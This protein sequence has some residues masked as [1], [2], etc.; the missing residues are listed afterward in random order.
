[1]ARWGDGVVSAPELG[2]AEALALCCRG[3]DAPDHAAFRVI[4]ERHRP[5]VEAFLQGLVGERA[6]VEDAVQDTFV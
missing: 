1:M 6:S 4:Y 5:D 3:E 2:E